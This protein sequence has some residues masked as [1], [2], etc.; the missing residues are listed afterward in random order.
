MSSLPCSV[1]SRPERRPLPL[2]LALAHGLACAR[3]RSRFA[4]AHN[5]PG[6]PPSVH[7]PSVCM[8]EASSSR[9]RL[10]LYSCRKLVMECEVHRYYYILATNSHSITTWFWV[11]T[12]QLCYRQTLSPP[13]S[14]AGETCMYLGKN[15]S[16][17]LSSRKSTKNKKCYTQIY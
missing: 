3:A 10:R 1:S 8:C 12:E 2:A 7:R 9:M 4:H 15:I 5:A 6:R 13:R 16:K 17:T 14:L 11:H